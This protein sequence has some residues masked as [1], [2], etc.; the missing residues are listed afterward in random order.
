MT[1]I[2]Q[3][4]ID[5]GT[6][7]LTGYSSYP[8]DY[9]RRVLEAAA[10]HIAAAERQRWA[11]RFREMAAAVL[12]HAGPGGMSLAELSARSPHSPDQ[13]RGRLLLNLADLLEGGEHLS[14]NPR[15]RHRDRR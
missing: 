2:P 14:R 12:P 6:Q 13:I 10:P 15:G 1:D 8:E 3:A 7:A 4:A 9:A 5:A 11:A